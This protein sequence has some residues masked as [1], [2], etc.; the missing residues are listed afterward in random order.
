[1]CIFG[2]FEIVRCIDGVPFCFVAIL[3][4]GFSIVMCLRL[5]FMYH[6]TGLMNTKQFCS[7]DFGVFGFHAFD[8]VGLVPVH[9]I[10]V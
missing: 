7:Y 5:F 9:H 10:N 1:M 2:T 4:T 3:I 6:K 8:Q